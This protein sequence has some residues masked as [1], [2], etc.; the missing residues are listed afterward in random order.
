VVSQ[1]E[2]AQITSQYQ[3]ALTTIPA[4]RRQLA[5]QENL[6]SILLGRNP[7]PIER[8]KTIEDLL[9][10]AIPSDLPSALLG[11]RPDI[12][13]AEQ[14]LIAANANI[15]ATQALYFPN[16]SLTGAV[17]IASTALDSVLGGPASAGVIGANLAGPIF[18]SGGIRG[19][20]RAA[21]AQQRQAVEFYQQTIINALRETNDALVGSQETREQVLEQE[22]R[23]LAL[24]EYSRL[25]HSRFDKGNAGY[26]EVLIAD[27]ELFAAEL[28][29]VQL[30]A[31]RYTQLVNVFQAMGGGW[32]DI[33]VSMSQE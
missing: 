14:N 10:P 6:I 26:L 9:A 27:N 12:L 32:V 30:L 22:K 18:T 21:K 20:V 13:Q 2:V 4:I 8:G 28:G 11:R 25:A 3:Q 1:V 16:I 17:G 23:V 24:R 7:G 5:A 15:G 19:E 33:V 31:D 29:S